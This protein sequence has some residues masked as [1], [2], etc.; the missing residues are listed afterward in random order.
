MENKR[1]G[2]Y[3]KRNN[4]DQINNTISNTSQNILLINLIWIGVVI[5]IGISAFFLGK[6]LC[7]KMRKKRAN[8]LDDDYDYTIN[9]ENVEKG[10]NDQDQIRNINEESKNNK[11]I[12]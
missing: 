1:L 3:A 5:I 8:E 10:I 4:V 11:L 7:N 9:E 2:F 12:D 6:L